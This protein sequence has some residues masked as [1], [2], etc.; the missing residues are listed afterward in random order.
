MEKREKTNP[1]L[2]EYVRKF[3]EL[4]YLPTTM[5]YDNEDYQ[6]LLIQ[7]VNR[8]KPLTSKEVA[9]F[10]NNQYDLVEYGK[11]FSNFKKK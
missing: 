6:V 1:A 11:G 10:F 3:D 9:D 4:P 5:T 8:G 7:A 2:K